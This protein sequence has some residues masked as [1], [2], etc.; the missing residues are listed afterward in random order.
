MGLAASQTRFLSL[1]ARKSD[2]EYQAQVLNTRRLQLADESAAAAKAYTDGMANQT[3][4]VS[5]KAETGNSNDLATVWYELNYANLVERGF[6]VIGM[7]GDQLH[8]SPYTEYLEGSTIDEKTHSSL[9]EQEQNLCVPDGKGGYVLK[10]TIRKDTVP[11]YNGMD[12]QTLLMSGQGQ[13]VDSRFFEYLCQHGYG[14]DSYY[15]LDKDGNKVPTT[16]ADLLEKWENDSL[17]GGVSATIDWRADVTSTFKATSYTE[18]DEKVAAAYEAKTAEIQAQ[19]KKLETQIKT[20]ETE[21][22]A[23]ETE[24][25]AVKKVIEKN[26]ENSYK[27]FA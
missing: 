16:Y 11:S 17:N 9:T 26:I 20:I 5:Y 27:S 25:E 6:Q 23:I 14:T 13:I 1:T 10:Q 24:M 2:L 22:K 4:R 7:A 12:I 21:H 3:I 15:N 8:P 19:D 18:D